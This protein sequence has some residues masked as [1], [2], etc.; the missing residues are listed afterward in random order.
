MTEKVGLMLR[1]ILERFRAY[2]NY[3]T[4][5]GLSDFA[6]RNRDGTAAEALSFPWCLVLRPGEEVR[7][8]A[9]GVDERFQGL[10]ENDGQVNFIEQILALPE[11]CVL[12]DIFAVPDPDAALVGGSIARR[13]DSAD[14]ERDG[15]SS[16]IR[17]GRMWNT[18]R[19]FRSERENQLFFKH[20]KKEEDYDLV[21]E[22]FERIRPE[23]QLYGSK[24]FE[25][26]IEQGLFYDLGPVESSDAT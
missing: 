3:P 13:D 10:P 20:Q 9:Q 17:I 5:L 7:R 11:D 16:L 8:I 25:R 18:T 19:F 12:Y 6:K 4:Q 22:W 23:H 14:G 1:P 2:S 24:E 26:R 21:P 15:R